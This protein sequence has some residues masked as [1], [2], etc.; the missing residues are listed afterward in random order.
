MLPPVRFAMP[1]IADTAPTLTALG[2]SYRSA[3]Q[4]SLPTTE[5]VQR[6]RSV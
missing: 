3:L 1:C 5:E 6:V 2:S 4:P